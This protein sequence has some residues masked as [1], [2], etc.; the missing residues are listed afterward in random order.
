[1]RVVRGGTR[2]CHASLVQGQGRQSRRCPGAGDCRGF[3]SAPPPPPSPA[4]RQ[5]SEEPQGRRPPLCQCVSVSHTICVVPPA[6]HPF[7]VVR[8]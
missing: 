2:G 7:E 4:C 8:L 6:H 3:V 1:M 5:R